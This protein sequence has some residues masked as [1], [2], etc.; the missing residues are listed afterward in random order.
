MRSNLLVGLKIAVY[1]KPELINYKSAGV[2]DPFASFSGAG[3]SVKVLRCLGFLG[4]WL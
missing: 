3:K 1:G 2:G 4:T